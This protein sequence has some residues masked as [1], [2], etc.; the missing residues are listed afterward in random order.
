MTICGACPVVINSPAKNGTL[1]SQACNCGCG[2]ITFD[3]A[4]STNNCNV[5]VCNAPFCTRNVILRRNTATEEERRIVGIVSGNRVQVD[6]D[7]CTVPAACDVYD[8]SYHPLDLIGACG[9]TQLSCSGCPPNGMKSCTNTYSLTTTAYLNFSDQYFMESKKCAAAACACFDV[10]GCGIFSTGFLTA[11]GVGVIGADQFQF[12]CATCCGNHPDLICTTGSGRV[13]MRGSYLSGAQ[14]GN[15]CHSNPCSANRRAEIVSVT[16]ASASDL[17]VFRGGAENTFN[18]NIMR[19]VSNACDTV[20]INACTTICGNIFLSNAGWIMNGTGTQIVNNQVFL[21]P[22]NEA[23]VIANQI[24]NF[25]CSTGLNGNTC[26]LCIANS[27]T[28]GF[29]NRRFK[30]LSTILD[31][32]GCAICGAKVFIGQH[33]CGDTIANDDATTSAGVADQRVIQNKYHKV[34]TTFTIDSF[35]EFDLH[36]VDYGKLPQ[37]RTLPAT[38]NQAFPVAL[39]DDTRTTEAEACAV[40]DATFRGRIFLCATTPHSIIKWT[41]GCGTL[42]E[43]KYGCGGSIINGSG[44]GACGELVDIIEGNTTAGTGVLRDRDATSYTAAG[45]ALTEMCGCW[46]GCFTMCTEQRF[47]YLYCVGQKTA[48]TGRTAVQA[49]DHMG[50]KLAQ[51]TLDTADGWDDIIIAGEDEFTFPYIDCGGTKFRTIRNVNNSAGWVLTGLTSLGCIGSYTDNGG[52]AFNPESSVTVTINV[53]DVCGCGVEGATVAVFT[54]PVSPCD[55]P[56][57][58]GTT[59]C[60]GVFTSSLTV[61]GDVCSTSRVRLKGF[62]SFQSCGTIDSCTGL[63]LDVRFI[64]DNIVDLP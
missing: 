23:A 7:W 39:L 48:C 42:T 50:A 63:T 33:T 44:S 4:L 36:H 54:S 17:F 14:P 13:R 35:G 64:S 57:L 5:C 55:T 9:T 37:T 38:N 43:G 46:T 41:N 1:G 51:A 47:D 25:D 2:E 10:L 59:N 58:C 24:F 62:Q 15:V 18:K 40:L 56:L 31:T 20:C 45:E 16:F 19:G 60:M 53:N 21:N 26:C 8:I 28:T 32:C 11:E 49:Y 52:T 29:I 12:K 30:S 34:G 22:T 6:H 61:G 3:T 27:Q